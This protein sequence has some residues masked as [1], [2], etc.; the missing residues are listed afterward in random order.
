VA[1]DAA[2]AGTLKAEKACEAF[3]TAAKGAGI[4][5]RED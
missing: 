5:V 2:L 1:A 3:V 4:F